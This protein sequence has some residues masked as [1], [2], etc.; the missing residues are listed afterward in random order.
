L[1]NPGEFTILELA[2]RVQ[3]LTGMSQDIQF[4]PL[5][6]DDPMQRQPVIKLAQ[7]LLDWT[8]SIPLEI[9]LPRTFEWFAGS[10]VKSPR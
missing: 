9:G 8:P 6:S 4:L 7:E 2:Q 5:P 10:T 1:G 3:S